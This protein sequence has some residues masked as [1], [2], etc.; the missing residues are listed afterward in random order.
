M[1]KFLFTLFFLAFVLVSLLGFSV[2]RSFKSFFFGSSKDRNRQRT[3]HNR[4][5]DTNKS[6]NTTAKPRSRK[7]VFDRNEGEY[8]E[9]E[10]IKD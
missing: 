3:V 6:Q 4:R 7:K 9:Y 2:I 8:T 1:L 5:T 10:E